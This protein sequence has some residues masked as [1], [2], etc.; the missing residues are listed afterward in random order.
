[1]SQCALNAKPQSNGTC[2][3]D[4]HISIIEEYTGNTISDI[5]KNCSN[6]D[7]INECI[8]D[9]SKAPDDIKLKIKIEALKAPTSSVDEKYWLDNTEIDTIMCQFRKMN[10]GFAHSCIHMS[11]LVM[12]PPKI[13]DAFDY[14]IY[15]VTDIDFANEFKHALH[16]RG[17]ISNDADNFT[18][19]LSTYNDKPLKSY[20]V[21]FNTDSSKGRG[22]HWFCIFIST[23]QKDPDN[24]HKPWIRIELFNSGGGGCSSAVFNKFW[25]QTATNIAK[26][27]GLKCTYDIITNLQHQSSETGNCGSYSLFYIY[28][29]CDG[30]IPSDFD[31]SNKKITDAEM[32]N[33]RLV[34]FEKKE[35]Y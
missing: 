10:N 34:C 14:H 21:I 3:T 22:K 24:T 26:A 30:G 23:D 25:A 15:P 35:T 7:N 31:K 9:N 5:T 33:F 13:I 12:I 27:T 20:G 2:L 11:D 16:K 28:A 6:E 32:T 19:K 8:I 18:P 17:I 1:M 4:E 29:R